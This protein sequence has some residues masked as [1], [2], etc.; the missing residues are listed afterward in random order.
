MVNKGYDLITFQGFFY[1]HLPIT[2]QVQSPG[3]MSVHIVTCLLIYVQS[4]IHHNGYLLNIL[5][6]STFVIGN[7]YVSAP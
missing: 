3:L 6:F 4:G 2:S 1:R 7:Q 5:S